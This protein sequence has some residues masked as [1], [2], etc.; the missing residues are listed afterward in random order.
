[1]KSATTALSP[2]SN[3]EKEKAMIRRSYLF[4]VGAVL[5]YVGS[6]NALNLPV[7]DAART[8]LDAASPAGLA[9][10]DI[11]ALRLLYTW[12]KA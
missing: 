10:R 8:I 1:M 7:A 2:L 3:G 9:E 12:P 5:L 11:A 6:A 4:A